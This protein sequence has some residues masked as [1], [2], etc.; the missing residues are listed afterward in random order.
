M[1]IGITVGGVSRAYAIVAL[2]DVATHVVNDLI[3]GTPV[4]V[5]Y[6]DQTECARVFTVHEKGAP[7]DLSVGGWKEDAMSLQFNNQQYVQTA[8]NIPLLDHPF[9]LTT[10]KEWSASHPDTDVYTGRP[11]IP[12]DPP[13]E[14]SGSPP[15]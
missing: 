10:W 2:S 13:V 9:E 5:T 8:S 14:G 1:V 11:P 4:S 6:C 3:D 12:P 15:D 7:I